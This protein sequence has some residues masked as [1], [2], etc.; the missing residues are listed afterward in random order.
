MDGV[1]F[2]RATYS[3]PHFDS[4]LTLS[5]SRARAR[6]RPPLDTHSRALFFPLFQQKTADA[7]DVMAQLRAM[8]QSDL[9]SLIGA[10][11]LAGL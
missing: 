5:L 10:G 7:A 6:V 9:S 3:Y 4:T 11:G 1:P 2:S 8:N